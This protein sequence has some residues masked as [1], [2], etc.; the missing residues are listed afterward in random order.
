[1]EGASRQKRM[2]PSFLSKD[3]YKASGWSNHVRLSGQN[4]ENEAHILAD[5]MILSLSGLP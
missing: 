3:L 4:S 2:H 5:S 1:M